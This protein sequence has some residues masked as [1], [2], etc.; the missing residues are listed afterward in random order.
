MFQTKVVEKFETHFMLNSFFSENRA[1][2]EMKWKIFVELGRP[3][4][5]HMCIACWI[6]KA[7][8]TYSE[9]VIPVAFPLQQWLHEHVSMLRYTYVA[10]LV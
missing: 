3:Q 2:Y 9:F 6:P 4:I 10:R 8:S 7:T 5:R 1:I